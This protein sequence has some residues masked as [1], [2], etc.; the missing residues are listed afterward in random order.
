[1]K[2]APIV[3]FTYARPDHTAQTLEALAKN[4]LASESVVY[5][6]CDGPR[7]E[8]HREKCEET[9]KL[10]DAITGFKDVIVEKSDVNR[11][12]A[13]SI[14]YGVTK[15]LD[16]H[17]RAIMVEDDLVSRPEFLPYMNEG[18]ER[19]KDDPKVFSVCGYAPPMRG[20]PKDYSYDAFFSYRNMS[21]GWSTWPD[22]WA[23]M[24]FEVRDFPAFQADKAMQKRFKRGGPDT[25]RL[26]F[27]QMEGRADTWD[28]QWNFT[29]FRHDG[30]ALLPLRSF[31]QNIG[32]D[33]SGTHFKGATDRYVVD[34]S[35]AK[36][37]E[38]WPP[39]AEVDPR[40][41]KAFAM[42]YAKTFRR[43]VKKAVRILKGIVGAEPK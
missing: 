25:V 18:L 27:D 36:R 10:V 22:R 31:I 20:I 4:E 34:L 13:S 2:L 23:K 32:T 3:L 24:D 11:G 7:R 12:L 19:Y 41:A 40:L 28:V 33:P 30:L 5:A 35:L 17:D 43:G 29:L 6:F 1:M 42:C 26:L 37:V 8:E 39:V 9:R 21:W 16:A 14:M 38:K 15:V